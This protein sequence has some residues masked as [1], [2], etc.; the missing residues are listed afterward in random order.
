MKNISPY[1]KIVIFYFSGTGNS[2]Q[3][4]YWIADFAK[5]W[6]IESQIISIDR[7]D[8]HALEKFNDDEL[9]ILTSPIHGFN[10]PKIVLDFISHF[11]KG[12]NNF[13]LMNTRAGMKIGKWVT[14]GLT[15]IAFLLSSLILKMKGYKIKGQIPFDLPSNW[16][17]IHPA[18]NSGTIQYLQKKI[19]ISLEFHCN[20]IFSGKNDF[21]ALRDIIQDILISPIA[22]LY[23]I[24]GRFFLAKSYYASLDCD[25]CGLC[26]KNCP[27]QAIKLV[28]GKP[29]WKFTCESCMRCMNACPKKAIET[30]HGLF[31]AVS[32]ISSTL[33]NYIFY[34]LFDFSSHS[35]LVNNVFITIFFF[36]VLWASYRIQHY[37][38]R[39]NFFEKIIR[40][41]SLTQ[42]KF[43]GRYKPKLK[44]SKI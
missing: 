31:V 36:L 23:Y 16:I 40:W 29:Y 25:D 9:L 34:K 27:V 18:L 33:T 4:A 15:G 21:H 3:I 7:I 6:N 19:Y 24:I 28:D 11:P 20:K 41:T 17:S 13:V 22:L 12:K 8:Y 35:W 37:L 32:I 38:L 14:P 10:Y 30:A 26:I 1:K 2:K 43:W 42:Y 5:K 39:F 44:K